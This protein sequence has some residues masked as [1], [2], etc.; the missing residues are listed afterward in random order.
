VLVDE[1]IF[2]VLKWVGLL[3]A[4]GLAIALRVTPRGQGR[5]AAK[6]IGGIAVSLGIGLGLKPLGRP[7]VI[8]KIPEVGEIEKTRARLYGGRT[9]ALQDGHQVR[10]SS[11]D[12][13][14]VVNDSPRTMTIRTISYG[15]IPSMGG[16]TPVGPMSLAEAPY[17]IDYVG[18][19][20]PPPNEV[21]SEI[22]FSFKYWLT[23]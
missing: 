1:S 8:V 4:A 15:S 9:Y 18:P 17:G 5:L 14:L 12:V 2:G 10:L 22:S 11:G 16:P 6:L 13:T 3:V 19:D 7:V 21:S 20:D 23:W